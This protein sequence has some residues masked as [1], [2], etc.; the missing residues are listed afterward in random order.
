MR[1]VGPEV[2]DVLDPDTQPDQPV[3]DGRGLGLPPATALEGRLDPAQRR[4]VH[5]QG[6]RARQEVGRV[7]AAAEYDGHDAAEAG[8]AHLLDH[9]VL[10]Q[11][12]GQL[13]GVALGPVQPEVER[14]HPAQGEPGLERAG[15]RADQVPPALQHVVQLV[16]GDDDRTEHRVGMPGEVLGRRV[17]D[18]VGAHGER[19]LPERGGEGVVDH[20]VGAGVVG[21]RRDGLDVG[22]LEGRVG[23]RLEPHQGGVVTGLHDRV[24]VG[25]VDQPGRRPAAGLEV[26]QLHDGAVVGVPRCDHDRA[27]PDQV[28]HGRDARQS[29]GE[30]QAPAALERAQRLLERRPGGVA[31]AAVLQLAGRDVRRRHRDRHVQR[32]IR[33]VL[34][35]PGGDG[36]GGGGP[37]T[38][39]AHGSEGTARAHR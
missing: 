4:G 24:R 11:P 1:Q 13:G 35:P 8:I 37:G 16:V 6:G 17:D 2:V 22:D 27:L 21:R 5:P 31:V 30:G 10:A 26:G 3:G 32:R 9:G 34:G 38:A 25:D 15:D 7:G 19:P 29:R 36:G 20:D 18:Q 39:L 12:A 14:A 28:E 23:G 33:S